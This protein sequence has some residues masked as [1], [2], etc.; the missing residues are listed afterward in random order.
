MRIIFFSHYYPPEVNAP[1]SRTSEHCR[2]WALAGH[3]VTVVTSAPN[4][5]RG[6]IY[7]GYRNRLFQV[8]TM[9][10]VKVVRV[11]TFLAA[12]EGFAL[13]TLN[14]LSFM[15][16]AALAVPRLP[17]PD[18]F[19]STSPQF[20]CG[21]TGL[22]ARV[23]RGA[24]WVLEI[25]DLWPESI[26]AVGA[27]RKGVVIRAL[28][29]L[30]RIAY[31][32]ADRIV[33]V[34]DS[35]VPHIAAR[36]G[37]AG[38]NGPDKNVP[39]MKASDKISVIK[40]GADLTLFRQSGDAGETRRRFG[41]DGRFVAAYVGTH[42]M[43]HGLD[44]IVDAAS[45]LR[46]DPRIGFLM[47]GDGA[48]RIRLAGKAAALKLDNLCVAG[49][50]PRADMPAI[51]TATD[52]SLIVLR[53][54]DTFLKV[55]PSKM[56]EA[57]AMARPIILGI[58]GESKTLLDDAGAGIAIT[59][60]SA[61]ELARAVVR[62]ADD[63]ALCERFGHRGAAYVR[64]HYDRARIAAHYLD[65]LAAVAARRAPRREGVLVRTGRVIAFARH[66][67]PGK[68]LRRVEIA[69]RRRLEDHVPLFRERRGGV[70]A[71]ARQPAPPLPVFAPRKHLAPAAVPGGARF[72]FLN[73]SIEMKGRVDWTA[74][75]P[76]PAHQLWR[77]N[78]HYMEYLEGVDDEAWEMLVSGWIAANPRGMR[79]AWQDSWN[80]YALSLRVVIWLQE[81]SRR[82]G[83]L[84]EDVVRRVEASAV[85]QLLF[86]ER[87]LETDLGGNHLM[88]NIKA[89]IWASAYFSGPAAV[90]W[91]RTGLAL[92]TRE[93]GRQ[94]LPDGMHNE[95][96][97]S[98]HAQVFADLLECRH[99]L[100]KDMFG[101][102]LDDALA[103]MAQAVADLTHPDGAPAL[104]NDAGM[105]MAYPPAACLDACE[106]L[107]G[108]RPAPRAVFAFRHAGYYG[109]RSGD[110]CFLADCGRIAPDDLPAHGH[111]DVLSFEWSV[112]GERII[113]DP[114]VY[115][116]AAGE[117][118]QR[119]RAAAS[120]NTL[121]FD[122]ADQADF[123]GAFRCGRRPDVEV[124]D[125]APRAGGFMLEGT[126]DGFSGLPG[127]P[128]HVRRFDAVP[129]DLV[130]TDRIEGTPA[131]PAQVAFLLHPGV[132]V[133]CAGCEATLRGRRAAVQM[134]S[135]QPIAVEPAVWWPDMGV[136]L[137]TRR[138]VV[139]LAPGVASVMTQFHVVES[140]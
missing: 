125:Y 66:M 105:S 133:T 101:G 112:A 41:L 81:L 60:E 117:R 61:G 126:H 53:R 68:I 56:F 82:S 75:G 76:G 90:R 25:R 110:T 6:V 21:L 20:F 55:L 73:R 134:T 104:F 29:W 26:V 115:E 86:L 49:Q 85:E 2:R 59:P 62:L 96:S 111:G 58:E 43:A 1:A 103:G 106:R 50:L 109:L 95:R 69:L 100:G 70:A 36:C 119:A 27:M 83:G 38:R 87:H 23:M 44:T 48:E 4:H 92:L 132:E 17:R 99:A 54:S 64:A 11:W 78:L 136:E 31:R 120:H 130:I 57:M 138:L 102:R 22:V 114:G 122:G 9:D 88:K 45:L 34:T 33:S 72:T 77:M 113:V 128:R 139:R 124:R 127:R 5:P 16:S 140:A 94:I 46:N 135:S 39:G 28:E 98:Y 35:F 3:D 89:L 108:R 107:S 123:F 63:P 18:V 12:N 42:G 74:P 84:P 71:V 65:V 15:V 91:R 93:L 118:R 37:T 131:Q 51:W 8:E 30:E 52:A 24:P 13:R 32:K 47:V 19:V 7:P 14:Y 129:D 10:G 40:N 121:C 80:S 97:A 79:G 137:A 116:Y 67:P